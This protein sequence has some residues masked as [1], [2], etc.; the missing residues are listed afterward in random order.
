MKT[1]TP[2]RGFT[3]TELLVTLAIIALLLALLI[4]AVQGSRES[5]RKAQCKSN[6]RQIGLALNNY[7]SVYGMWPAAGLPKV[8]SWHV[9]LLPFIDQSALFHRVNFSPSP[10]S[11]PAD[12]IAH[13]PIRLYLCPSDPAPEV[14]SAAITVAATN[15]LGN[16]G[17]GLMANGYDGMFSHM[18]PWNPDE[19]PEGPV[20]LSEVTDGTSATAA[21]AE[22]MHSDNRSTDRLRLVF[23]TP[24]AFATAEI[25]QFKATCLGIPE[26]PTTHGWRG[27]GQLHGWRWTFGEIGFSTYNHMLPPMQPSCNNGTGVQD[28]IYTASSLHGSNINLL[29]ADGHVQSVSSGIDRAVWASIG[30][31]NGSEAVQPQF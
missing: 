23:N 31:R 6:L 7:E 19:Y 15:Y 20:K 25:D 10:G 17:S 8:T 4:P 29:F 13:V 24:T 5:A 16:S 21:V 11:N 2:A 30:S 28:G 1:T 9:A 12:S 22:V 27:T 14:F 18:S 3:L 26:S